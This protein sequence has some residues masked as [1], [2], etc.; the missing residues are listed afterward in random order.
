MLLADT[1]FED[2]LVAGNLER[3]TW[4]EKWKKDGYDFWAEK[5]FLPGVTDNLAKTI[6]EA[7]KL[8][9]ESSSIE[10]ASGKTYLLKKESE[11]IGSVEDIK[12][13]AAYNWY[14]PLVENFQIYDLNFIQIEPHKPRLVL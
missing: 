14:H 12:K 8:M 4:A 11:G 3:K 1:N 9:G 6:R 13:E 5:Q 10:V 7:L 2:C